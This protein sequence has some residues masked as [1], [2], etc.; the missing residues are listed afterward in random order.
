M[1]P[2][3]RWTNL[4]LGAA[5][6][7]YLVVELLQLGLAGLAMLGAE[8]SRAA[9]HDALSIHGHVVDCQ[10]LT[11]AA[12]LLEVTIATGVVRNTTHAAAG[13]AHHGSDPIAHVKGG[14]FARRTHFGALLGEVSLREGAAAATIALGAGTG[15][16]V[17]PCLA[18][19]AAGERAMFRLVIAVK[20][21]MAG[22]LLL[23]PWLY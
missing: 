16:H 21:I 5:A 10:V 23:L 11:S 6:L 13:F 14:T 12:A 18:A 2:R 15:V 8:P 22:I 17:V 4:L 20:A 9:H 19:V 3:H 1:R 7:A